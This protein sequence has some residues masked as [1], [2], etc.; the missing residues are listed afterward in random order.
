M[1][2]E[3]KTLFF[4]QTANVLQFCGGKVD[5]LEELSMYEG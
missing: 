1:Y 4:I 3:K 2:R 5:A